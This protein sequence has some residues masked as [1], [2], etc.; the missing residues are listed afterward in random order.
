MDKEGQN[1]SSSV[2]HS[3]SIGS[4]VTPEYFSNIK[5]GKKDKEKVQ[6]IRS[7]RSRKPLFITLG[8]VA[9]IL[10]IIMIIAL[11]RT[12]NHPR[13][14]RTDEEMPTTTS[15]IES[16]A[17]KVLYESGKYE[18]ALAYLNDLIRDMKDLGAS[19]EQIFEAYVVR[20]RI[21]YQAGGEDVAI[22][23]A[24]RLVKEADTDTKKYS[25]YN[26]L[27]FMYSQ[28]KNEEMSAFYSE[29]M[30]ELNVPQNSIEGEVPIADEDSEDNV[31]EQEPDYE[32]VEE[33]DAE[34][35]VEEGGEDE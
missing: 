14:S 10:L 35:Y 19:S 20:A 12:F 29:M 13:G 17:Y 16:R 34:T 25:I 3:E 2:F 27:Y 30:D 24:L 5:G 11:V 32:Y 26:V 33:E 1:T 8:V 15:E 7:E 18:N 4:Q 28:E 23:E 21:A 31:D 22:Q 9:T 6:K